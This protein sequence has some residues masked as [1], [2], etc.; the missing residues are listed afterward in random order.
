MYASPTLVQAAAF[1]FKLIPV[2]RSPFKEAIK[3]ASLPVF[4]NS[5]HNS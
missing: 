5:F 3:S 4:P 1:I 2:P